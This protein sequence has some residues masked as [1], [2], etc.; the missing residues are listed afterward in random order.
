MRRASCQASPSWSGPPGSCRPGPP[1]PP[2]FSMKSRAPS[3]MASTAYLTLACPSQ[4]DDLQVRAFLQ[5]QL[6]GFQAVEP[7][8]H[9]VE[10][11]GVVTGQIQLAQGLLAAGGRIHHEIADLEA[12]ADSLPGTPPRRRRSK[13][14]LRPWSLSSVEWL[15]EYH[16]GNLRIR[17]PSSALSVTFPWASSSLGGRI[18]SPVS[19]PSSLR[20]TPSSLADQGGPDQAFGS[21]RAHGG[22]QGGPQNLLQHKGFHPDLKGGP[23]LRRFHSQ[24]HLFEPGLSLVEPGHQLE[25]LEEVGLARLLFGAVGKMC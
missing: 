12:F 11:Y 10:H 19:W 4:K 7:G 9:Q 22:L 15:G 21:G 13:R 16:P 23:L 18:S 6:E 2:A 5:G 25:G 3:C 17:T 14:L 8:H 1:G 20:E 24:A